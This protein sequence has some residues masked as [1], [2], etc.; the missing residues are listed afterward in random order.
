MMTRTQA[1]AVYVVDP[2]HETAI[3]RLKEQTGIELILPQDPRRD[4][5]LERATAVMVRSETILDSKSISK[6][7]PGLKYI[8][9]QGVGVDNIDTEAASAKGI[10]VYN[11]PGLN[12]E[13]VAE[14]T[15]G[16]AMCVAR[17]ICEFDRKIRDGEKVVRSEMLGKSLNGKTLGVVG[18][19]NIGF[20]VAKKWKGAMDGKIVAFDPY[21]P[22]HAWEEHLGSEL[23]QRADSL[24]EVLREADVVTLHMPL[25]ASTSNMIAGEQMRLMKPG[26]ILLNCARGG[27]VDETALLEALDS[28][29]IF[30]AGLDAVQCEPPTLSTYG[31]TLLRHSRVVVTPHVGASTSENQEKSGL[32]AVDILS[33]L[34]E[35]DLSRVPKTVV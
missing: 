27:I 10:R 35:G 17:R 19:G 20:E 26:A 15:I 31:E 14:L 24:E 33:A 4:E 21:S 22:R 16:L 8:I 34:L 11:T 28:G 2:Y 18:M 29:H 23:L 13:A 7:N 12:S 5:F 30:G 25:T 3:A 32:A 9:K 6:A 1:P